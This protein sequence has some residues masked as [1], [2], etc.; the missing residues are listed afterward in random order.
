[1]TTEDVNVLVDV[2]PAVVRRLLE[3]G[4][5]VDD[6]DVVV[7][8]HFHVDHTADLSTFFFACNYGRVPRAKPLT[9][10]GGKGLARFYR[11]FRAIYPWITPK[12]YNLTV[13][14]LV[15]DS[16]TLFGLTIT[17][18]PV[19]HNPESIAVRLEKK[20]SIT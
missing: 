13:K 14:R 17:T 10:I 7:L 15:N 19:N 2:G 12:S 20:R 5:E 16:I 3:R 18:V 9:V 6:V 1:M 8:T 11:G 4:Y